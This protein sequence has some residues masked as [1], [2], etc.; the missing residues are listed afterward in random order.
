MK[1]ANLL[2]VDVMEVELNR[3]VVILYLFYWY[4]VGLYGWY[5]VVWLCAAQ[6]VH[7]WQNPHYIGVRTFSGVYAALKFIPTDAQDR[8]DCR[9][10]MNHAMKRKI[11][12]KEASLSRDKLL[13]C[14]GIGLPCCKNS[15]MYTP[16]HT[17]ITDTYTYTPIYTY[18]YAYTL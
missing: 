11:K 9:Q 8:K 18:I 6:P 10:L 5:N 1:G 15:Y 12:F 14:Y 4:N 7:A 17:P 13:V 16:I 3:V 2:G